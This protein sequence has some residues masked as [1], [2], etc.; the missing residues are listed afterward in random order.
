MI[1]FIRYIGFH[2]HAI[3]VRNITEDKPHGNK[4]QNII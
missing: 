2:L 1:T 4:I 3:I